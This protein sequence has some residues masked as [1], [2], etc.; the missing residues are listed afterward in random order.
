MR[1]LTP[2]Q[3][4]NV[5]VGLETWDDAGVFRV[6][7][8]LALVQTV[9]FFTP[10]VDEPRDFGAVAAANALSDCYAMGGTPMTA[11]GIVCFPHKVLPIE[12]LAET[13]AGAGE[14]LA[15]AEV[16][17]LG[18]HSVKDPEFKF[19]L[20]VT[21]HVHPQRIVRNRGAK[22]GDLLM[23]TKP[24]G[25]GILSTAIKR[26]RLDADSIALL[27]RTMRTL[28][29]D[30]AAA[31]LAA[32]ARAATDITG[33]GLMGHGVGMARASG[34]TF[35]F[36][37]ARVPVL[38][39]ALELLAEGVFPGGLEDNVRGL[40]RDVHAGDGPNHRLLFDPQTSGGLLVSLAPAAEARFL[41][42]LANRKA[43]PAARVGE[44]V[45]RGPFWVE[46]D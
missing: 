40:A 38:P 26:D 28:N 17:L 36:H 35:R 3:N 7:D 2:A 1:Q 16:S 24:L 32:G 44:V 22:P 13:M 8:E 27:V 19:G 4:P 11:L 30:A 12:T 29:R 42:E 14:V 10:I 31:M 46:V 33:F 18:G 20:A 25:T 39:H 43:P 6:S 9:D 41:E 37:S 21:G 5:L 23:L 15:E 45:E 34:V